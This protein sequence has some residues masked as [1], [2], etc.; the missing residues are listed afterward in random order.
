MAHQEESQF[1][2]EGHDWLGTLEERAG[3]LKDPQYS[4]AVLD[5]G[6]G[7]ARALLDE[8]RVPEAQRKY[9]QVKR[10]LEQA[11]GSAKALSLAWRLLY[12]Q[13]GY[14]FV[15][16]ALG[17]LAHKLPWLWILKGFITWQVGEAWFI[18]WQAGTAW[19]GALGGVT[20]GIFGVFSHIRERNFDPMFELW[21]ISKPI[22]GA[23][24]GWF[25]VVVYVVGLLAIQ[26]QVKWQTSNPLLLYVVAFLAGFSERYTIQIINQI[27]K[28]LTA[29]QTPSSSTSSESSTIK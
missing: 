10:L 17:F 22:V 4:A 9:E 13:F 8:G 11:E 26:G 15:L 12:I 24:F 16:L 23:I 6:I 3:K 28:V 18:S 27:M 5:K 19:F 2:K 14:L 7:D 25:V 1:E 29:W 20:I 21:Y